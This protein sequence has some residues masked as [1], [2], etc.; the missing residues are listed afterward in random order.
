[1]KQQ[2]ESRRLSGVLYEHAT[3]DARLEVL[4]EHCLPNTCPQTPAPPPSSGAI[5]IL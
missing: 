2:Y 3:E 1:M 4:L 5:S